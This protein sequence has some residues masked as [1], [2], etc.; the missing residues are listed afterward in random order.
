MG[1]TH[2]S[3]GFESL[4]LDIFGQVERINRIYTQVTLC[5]PVP[6][7]SVSFREKIVARLRGAIQQLHKDLPWTA[8]RVVQQDGRFTIVPKSES[9]TYSPLTVKVL[10]DDVTAHT[11]NS[12]Q[13]A[14][15]PCHMLDEDVIAPCKT[16]VDPEAERPVLLVQ[17]N[18][19]KGGLLLTFNGQHG[20]MDMTG[21]GQLIALFAK[22]CRGVDF[23]LFEI[24]IGNLKREGHIPLF[25]PETP[26]HPESPQSGSSVPE[27]AVDFK[28]NNPSEY[29][30]VWAN[31]NFTASSLGELKSRAHMQVKMQYQKD[32]SPST[33]DH[34]PSTDDLL[35][36]FI[37]QGITRVRMRRG[38]DAHGLEVVMTELSRNVD[39]RSHYNLPASYPGFMVSS[40]VIQY[41]IPEVVDKMSRVEIALK[42]RSKLQLPCEIMFS[43][44]EM[45]TNI[46]QKEYEAARRHNAMERSPGFDVRLSSW[47]K[48][49]LYDLDFGPLLGR[50]EAVRRPRFE[51]G[52]REGLVYFLPK[53]R[54]KSIVVA[55]CLRGE[56]M[57][58]LRTDK[59]F[60]DWATWIG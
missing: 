50:P 26:D 20:S 45:A 52:A 60:L 43:A 25:K 40:T 47:A 10:E 51:H 24:S 29:P 17:A 53:G 22:A 8:G 4:T 35:T 1:S 2:A 27:Q 33:D 21:Q 42:L 30:L 14:E 57:D 15:F 34:L 39:I 3:P 37:W 49:K 36:A 9:C 44:E 31:F 7:D 46:H 38:A 54:D 55:I 48:E 12:L 59:E 23:T 11:W 13:Q 56:D 16:F 41:F 58:R 18:F 5:F 28:G 19:V 32:Y 6:D